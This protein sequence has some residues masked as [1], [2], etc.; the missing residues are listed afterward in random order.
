MTFR[1]WPAE[2]LEFY[3]GLA[4]DNSK[5]YWTKHLEFYE[6]R[7]RGPMEELLAALEPEFGP[8]KIFRP[9]RDVRFSKDKSPYKTHLGAW[10]NA[11]GYLQLSADGLA[12][13]SGYYQMDP[14]QLDRY[15]RAVVDDRTGAELTEVIARIEKAGFGVQG[16]GTLKTAPRGYPKD[17]PRIE[18]LRHKGLIT[19]KEWP[20]AAWL[21][22]AAAQKK[23]V[24]FL[25]G[26]LP[27]RHWLDDHVG[28][29]AA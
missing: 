23:I 21:G 22:T 1:G 5:T 6:T 18:L 4:A 29:P 26:S 7:V 24:D 12:A 11:G 27:L 9:Y 28:P 19:W 3:E 25:R 13:G 10:L 20:P 8:G 17:H 15:R 14:A 2:A 16:H